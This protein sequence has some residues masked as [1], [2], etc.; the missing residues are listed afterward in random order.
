VNNL[1]ASPPANIVAGDR[2]TPTQVFHN[3]SLFIPETNSAYIFA[4]NSEFRSHHIDSLLSTLSNN[5][6]PALISEERPDGLSIIID[7]STY[8][9]SLYSSRRLEAIWQLLGSSVLYIDITGLSHHVWAALIQSALQSSL[10]VRV[11][12]VEP[13]TYRRASGEQAQYDLSERIAGIHPLPGF[14]TL[15]QSNESNVSFIPLLGFEEDRL[16]HAINR[17]DPPANKT[18]PVIGIPGFRPEFPFET[19]DS[20][21]RM[22]MKERLWASARFADAS[23]PFRLYYLIRDIARN[24]IQDKI[25]IALLGTKPHALG[26]VL[27]AIARERRVELVYDHPIRKDDRT[28]GIRRLMVYHVSSFNPVTLA[29]QRLTTAVAST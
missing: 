20:N 16:R 14:A 12:Y 26:A 13:D 3:P 5:V 29:V 25:K 8:E 1:T 22:L 18:F 2:I 11:V 27:Y 15:R 4:H 6:T 19:Y 23:C 21:R 7:N 9:V 24:N 17:V 28:Q 10:T